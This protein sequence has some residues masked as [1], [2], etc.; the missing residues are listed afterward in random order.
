[1]TPAEALATFAQLQPSTIR[2]GLERVSA[3]LERLGRPDHAYRSLQ[4]AGTN[5]KGSTCAFLA[6][7][8]RESGRRVGLYTSPHLVH[9][10]ERIQVDGEAIS[11]AEFGVALRE[12]FLR[13]PEALEEPPSLT[14]FEVGTL[15]ALVHFQRAG[16][17]VAV[18]ETGLGGRLDAT[19]AARVEVTAIATIA[20]DHTPLLGTTLGEIA[21][22][23]AG[24]LREGVP[25]AVL[26]QPPE[27]E[28]VLSRCAAERG[29]PLYR[30]GEH[31]GLTAAG[32][33]R[34]LGRTVEGL[35]PGLRGAHQRRNAALAIATALL[36]D[37]SLSDDALRR[38]LSQT[39]WPGRFEQVET[40]P[41]LILD[42]AHNPE[43]AAALRAALA[44]EYPGRRVHLV[45]G[46]L[47]DKD[48]TRVRAA[49]FPGCASIHL[50]PVPS[51]RSLPP[52]AS[53]V[54]ARRHSGVVRCHATWQQALEAARQGAASDEVIVCAGSLFL[55][56]AVRAELGKVA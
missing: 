56:G 33:F 48:H 4:V 26:R 46:V 50:C 1:M 23:K 41:D 8:L 37:P 52:E 7:L 51:P 30:E 45:F 31:F 42:G 49:L 53:V 43:G 44:A 10:N 6:R 28:A 25:V 24:I 55:I 12:V 18:L 19:T 38:G 34:G 27:A 40:G 11:D 20:L 36:F 32:C 39:R 29:A 47:A 21:R 14:Y 13:C 35:R 15:A 16:V 54:E 2:L 5:G 3:A 22:E 17:E 9:P